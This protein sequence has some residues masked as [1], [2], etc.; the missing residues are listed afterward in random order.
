[1]AK[2]KLKKPTAKKAKKKT[3][4]KAAS[5]TTGTAIERDD[6]KRAYYV[7]GHELRLMAARDYIF[8]ADQSAVDDLYE[9]PDRPYSERVSLHT[10]KKWAYEDGWTPR[11]DKFWE[12]HEQRVYERMRDQLLRQRLEE[13]RKRTEER[14]AMA[15]YLR[16]RRDP[17]TDEI[18]YHPHTVTETYVDDD[19]EERT[20]TRPHPLAGLPILPLE[21]PRLDQFVNAFVKF[22]QHLMVMRGEASSRTEQIT[23][24][25]EDAAGRGRVSGDLVD[26]VAAGMHID[27]ED[28]QHMARELLRRRQPELA[29]DV[30]WE[31]VDDSPSAAQRLFEEDGDDDDEDE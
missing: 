23:R 25:P 26:P 5:K 1:M 7:K 31:E 18:L 3:S 19:G 30:D 13:V 21:V 16:P 22:D 12:E 6:S 20:T 15:A 27:D 8:D 2:K 9:R 14:D 24:G 4:K 10:F 11:R 28:I 29:I 17:D